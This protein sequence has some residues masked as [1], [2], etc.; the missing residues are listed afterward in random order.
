MGF[1]VTKMERFV[2]LLVLLLVTSCVRDKNQASQELAAIIREVEDH[3]GFDKDEFPLGRFS[4]DYYAAEAEF[5]EQQLS[6]LDQL[7]QEKLKESEL[8]SYELLRFVLQSRIDF[9]TFQMYLNPLLSDAG[10]HS[11]LVYLVKPLDN[12]DQTRTYLDKLNDIPRFVDEHFALL[13]A[14]LEKGVSQPRIIFEGYES[15][16]ETHITDHFEDSYF[17]S[18]FKQ[19]PSDLN[20][21][22]KDSVLAE[23]KKSIEKNVIPQFKR[24]REFFEETYYP[25]TRTE[26]GI[27]ATPGGQ[28]YYQNRINYYTTSEQ[29]TAADIHEIGLKEVARI[30][31]KM[32]EVISEL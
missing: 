31:N 5:A 27:S 21:S 9:D 24:I 30:R 19:L 7:E 25:N 8:I 17:Y 29:Y 14:G 1:K 2:G 4:G 11:N 32:K 13:K 15:S 23:A 18:P 3:E 10:F 28:E 6:R 22:Q 20:E 16:Y 12:Y 26:I